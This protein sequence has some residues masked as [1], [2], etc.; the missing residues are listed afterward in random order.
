M[1]LGCN[2]LEVR[3]GVDEVDLDPN[4]NVFVVIHRTTVLGQPDG[5]NR[6]R[7]A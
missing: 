7:H 6:H 1:V 2:I 3:A 4:W 5:S